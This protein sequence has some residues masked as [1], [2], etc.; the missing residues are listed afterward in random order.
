M[1]DEQGGLYMQQESGD[2]ALTGRATPMFRSIVMSPTQGTRHGRL[3]ISDVEQS[4]G[5]VKGQGAVQVTL[6][7]P[8][9]QITSEFRLENVNRTNSDRVKLV[10]V[11][12][13]D[14]VLGSLA[15]ESIHAGGV[16]SFAHGNITIA[17]GALANRHR[18]GS[19]KL[20]GI[21][22]EPAA[23]FVQQ[24]MAL[25]RDGQG[26]K[27]HGRLGGGWRGVLYDFAG[28]GYTKEHSGEGHG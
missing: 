23:A 17:S 20:P 15:N 9:H 14:L 3:G 6:I 28:G 7:H 1:A 22:V 5:R 24:Q 16:R 10:G 18:P 19:N 12:A 8:L 25:G 2:G 27:G 13:V 11:G 4:G 26:V 21:E